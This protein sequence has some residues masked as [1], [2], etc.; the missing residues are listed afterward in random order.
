[1]RLLEERD[2]GLR[3]LPALDDD[4][5]HPA[6]QRGFQRTVQLRRH[7]D[8][9]A[10][11]AD[12]ACQGRSIFDAARCRRRSEIGR[13]ASGSRSVAG[14][15]G[16]TCAVAARRSH[17]GACAGVQPGALIAETREHLLLILQPPQRPLRRVQLLGG[18]ALRF[19]GR[20]QRQRVRLTLLLQLR[21]IAFSR[22]KFAR[23]R[24]VLLLEIGQAAPGGFGGLRLLGLGAGQLLAAL[25]R[26]C[27]SRAPIGQLRAQRQTSFLRLRQPSSLSLALLLQL[28]QVALGHTDPFGVGVVSRDRRSEGRFS[29]G[30]ALSAVLEACAQMEDFLFQLFLLLAPKAHLLGAHG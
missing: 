17:D 20:C 18:L 2:G 23:Q 11:R 9:L 30:L 4:I 27:Q 16:R 19:L 1:M 7:L 28:V 29:A 5:L 3:I 26:L 12:D 6:A 22:R 14:C 13:E 15:G 8:Q 24:V 10:E 21:K 25:A